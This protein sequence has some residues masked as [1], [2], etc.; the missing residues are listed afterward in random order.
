MDQED[1]GHPE[2]VEIDDIPGLEFMIGRRRDKGLALISSGEVAQLVE[3]PH[4]SS[5]PERHRDQ[6]RAGR[7]RGPR[8][9]QPPSGT[10]D[11]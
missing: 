7:Q 6:R 2:P 5:D 4:F 1:L 11:A 10:G 3:V 8:F 9:H